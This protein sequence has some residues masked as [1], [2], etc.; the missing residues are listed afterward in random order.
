[1]NSDD[2]KLLEQLESLAKSDGGD[3][4]ENKWVQI[5]AGA[6]ICCALGVFGV[7]A[8]IEFQQNDSVAREQRQEQANQF[9]EAERQLEL[10]QAAD[11]IAREYLKAGR[12]IYSQDDMTKA[13]YVSENLE[14]V[15]YNTNPPQALTDGLVIIDPN[16]CGGVL[17]DG[18]VTGVACVLWESPDEWEQW[19]ISVFGQQFAGVYTNPAGV[20]QSEEV[21][22]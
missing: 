12:F 18:R 14:V 6:A 22:P 17:R 1:M 19:A 15:D 4:W 2:L 8:L 7:P 9:T 16:G 13:L 5:G 10:V 21:T 3:W 20:V 11:P